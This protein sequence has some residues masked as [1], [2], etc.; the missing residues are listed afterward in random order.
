MAKDPYK[1]FRV[2]A[3]EL[4]EG[5]THGVLDL[6]KGAASAELVAHLLRLAH[7][8]K[9]A[10]RVVK[11]R[12]IAEL[13]HGLEETLTDLRERPQISKEQ[14]SALLSVL[15]TISAQLRALDGPP[16]PS[17]SPGRGGDAEALETVR[18]EMHELDALFRGV[19][20]ATVRL[21][22]VRAGTTALEHVGD[23][24]RA[25]ALQ[26]AVV[27]GDGTK[28][29]VALRRAR[30]IAD[31][32]RGR[33][34]SAQRGLRG[35][36]DR[37]DGE[38][39]EV[40]E[41]AHRLGLVPAHTIF[42]ALDRSARD[43]AQALGKQVAFETAG[44]D[45]RLDAGV[46][47]SIRDA[48]MHVVRNAVVH[49]VET[50]AERL[51]AGKPAI[52]RVLLRVE[53][54]GNRVAILCEDDGRG[55]DVE[56]VG[57]AA[58]RRGLVRTAAADALTTEDA[59]RLLYGGGLS[60]STAVTELS[61]RGI[62]LDVVRAT[63]ARLK[64][65]A[66]IRS[67]SGRGV[68]VELVVP[69][70]V[71]S[72]QAL[73]VEH[74][75]QLAAVPLDAVRETL[76]VDESDI[77]RSEG[78]R[79]IVSDAAVIPFVP[80]DSVLERKRGARAGRAW[81]A[82]VVAA[83]H[84]R[85]AIGVDRLVGTTDVVVRGL[86]D[87]VCADPIVSGV[88]FDG[89]GNPQLVLDPAGLVA[90][91]GRERGRFADEPGAKAAPI[92][93]IDDSLTTRMLEQSILESAGYDVE[94]AVSAEEGLAKARE[95]RYSLFVVDVEMPGIDGFEL[96]A[97]TR[98]DPALRDV[99]AI[100]VTSRNAPEDRRRGEQVGA[101]AYIVKSEFDQE[102]LLHIVRELVG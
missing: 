70:S 18:V 30:S 82:V 61:G 38:L 23:L 98:A 27:D 66:S 16:T 52:G 100:L 6:E 35:D 47:A 101:H 26:L 34:E 97:R 50:E 20:E 37:V 102:Q 44:G 1:Y 49:G 19:S 68:A 84:Q 46:L 15:D 83:G 76:R 54:R 28:T 53:R 75:G 41:L 2:E 24:A 59:I 8:L 33:I 13:A 55:V 92:L 9:G 91:A 11:Q 89:E 31:E 69:V 40:R 56:A 5:L 29:T 4:V 43:A 60:T 93:V 94:L 87:V 57:A 45:V 64:G 10:A 58:V 73:V 88:S 85:L 81:C 48:L 51:A 62:G 39:T 96:V 32:L 36:L 86:P 72:L 71:A 74:G 22:A 78:T 67:A 90:A 25:L 99:P 21:G 17:P 79:S 12:G 65:E 7:T 95:R 63:A 42:P 3:R 77:A 14:G 80:L